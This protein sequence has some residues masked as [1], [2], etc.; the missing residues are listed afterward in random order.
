MY[1]FSSGVPKG[2]EAGGVMISGQLTAGIP[3][4]IPTGV[5]LT[6]CGD[7]T[8]GV[9]TLGRSSSSPLPAPQPSSVSVTDAPATSASTRATRGDTR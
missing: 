9:R 6:S 1:P 7:L 4:V 8:V 3:G 5:W 2:A